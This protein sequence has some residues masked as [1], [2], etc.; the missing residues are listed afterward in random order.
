K[1]QNICSGIGVEPEH[2]RTIVPL[3]KNHDENVKTIAEELEYKG[4][5]VIIAARECIQTASRRK[6]ADASGE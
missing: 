2:I 1:L 4:V 5:S 6:K 3:R